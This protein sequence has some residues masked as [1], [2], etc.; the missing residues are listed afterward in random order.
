MTMAGNPAT[1]FVKVPSRRVPLSFVPM[2]I[3]ALPLM[4]I[5]TFIV[6]AGKIGELWTI[7]LMDL[8]SDRRRPAAAR[9]R[10]LAQSTVSATS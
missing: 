1:A 5:A 3:L 2:F 6:V 10:L 7:G 4:E 8:S 9:T